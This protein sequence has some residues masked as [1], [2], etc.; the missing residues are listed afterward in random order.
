MA[1]LETSQGILALVDVVNFTSQAD[2]L[3][4]SYTARYTKYFQRKIKTI[5]KKYNF[6]VVKAFGDA[7]LIFGP[8]PEDLLEIMLDLFERVKPKD[9]YGFISRFRMVAHSGYFQ[10]RIKYRRPVDLVSPEGIKVFRMEKH[11]GTWELMVTHTLFQGLNH[12]LNRYRMEAHR[13]VLNEPLKGFDSQEWFP[14]FYRLRIMSESEVVSN[15]LERRLDEL[16]EGV[17]FIPVFGR[18]YDPVRM[19]KNFVN[20]AL[21]W[22]PDRDRD[23]GDSR[24]PVPGDLDFKRKRRGIQEEKDKWL[25]HECDRGAAD[26]VSYID[27]PTLYKNHYRGIIIGLPG[28][29]K[30][31]ILK[32]LAYQEFKGRVAGKEKGKRVILFVPCQGIPLYVDWHNSRFGKDTL[33]PKRDSALEYLTWIFIFGARSHSDVTPEELVEFQGAAKI[34]H[35]A[36]RDNRLT[37]LVDALDEAPDSPSKE[38]IMELFL[39]LA[40]NSLPKT[41]NRFFLTTR[42]S[43]RLHLEQKEIPVFYV[44]SLNLEQVRAVARNLMEEG[45]EI[46][47]KFDQAI[48]QEE[49]VVKMAATPLTALLVTAY[50][51]A[52]EKFHHRFSMYDMLVKF[53]LLRIWESIKAGTFPYKKLDL[54]FQEIKKPGFL[55]KKR[56]IRILYDALASLCFELFY[57]TSD[58][59]IQRDVGEEL[60][61]A[62]FNRFI[63]DHLPYEKEGEPAVQADRW[64]ERFHQDHLLLKAS[65]TRYVFVHSMVMEFLAAYHLVNRIIKNREE[66]VPLVRKCLISKD[67]KELETLPIAAGSELK[68]VYA[69]LSTMRDLDVPYEREI[70]HEVAA[71]CLA[72]LEWQI[73]KTFQAITLERLTKPI[74]D[75]IMQ[76]RGAV[77]WLYK[78]LKKLVLTPDKSCL[79]KSTRKF[80][81]VLKLSQDTFLKEYL[82]YE[83]FDRGDSE[84]VGLRKELLFQLVQK[85]LVEQWLRAHLAAAAENGWQLD[86]P[87]FHFEDKNFRY[88]QAMMGQELQGFLGSPNMRHSGAVRACIFSPDGMTFVS[89]S[90]D[91]TLKLWNAATGKEIRTFIGHA[92][93]V[94]GC[95]FSPDGTLLVSASFD[96]TLKLWEVTNSLEIRTFTGHQGPVLSCSFSPDGSHLASASTDK[97]IKLWKVSGAKAIRTFTGHKDAVYDCTFSPD[98]AYLVSTSLDKTLKLWE[99]ASGKEIR[100]FTGHKAAVSSC[101]FSLDGTNL[102]SASADHTLK[103]WEVKSGKATLTFNEHKGWVYN[104]AFS[105]DGSHLVSASSDRTL[106]LWEVNSGK[107]IRAFTGHTDSVWGCAFSPGGTRLVSASRDNT[108][109]LWEVASGKEIRAFTGHMAPVYSCTFS[110]TG[111]HLVS[112][113]RDKTLKLWEMASGKEIRTFSGH[114]DPVWGCAFSPDGCLLVSASEDK[115]LK[116]WEI[117]S[118]KEIRTFTGH[119]DHIRACAFSPDG[120]LLVSASED[121]TLKLWEMTSGKEIRTFTGH[122]DHIRACAF[123]PDGCLL[124]SASEDETLKLWDTASG[125]I[126][127]FFRRHKDV[128]SSCAFSPDG[129]YLVS[130]SFDKT[131]KLWKLS[132]RRAIRTLK[133]H[134]D[135]VLNCDF[136]QSG[137][138]LVSVSEDKTLKLWEVESGKLLKSMQLPWIPQHV[139]TAKDN[140]VITANENGTLTLFKFEEL[141]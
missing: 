133:G 29:G 35:K 26:E 139:T 55:E 18:I 70:L 127:R 63:Q 78:Y 84:L 85:E 21:Q 105:P 114:I 72:E 45:S 131:L 56:E 73:T 103:L 107:E 3:G 1:D 77:D 4:D 116:L 128:V 10:F 132:N 32:H 136:S 118:G 67:Y 46:Y 42:P 83:D 66:L 113:S 90:D 37:L 117:A 60:L 87:L 109:K 141:E 112:S 43:E 86:S 40:E 64:I 108:L 82:S 38:K 41:G 88:F 123:S 5:V 31:T 23:M 130:A 13:M 9:L 52:Y 47:Q 7:V 14:P 16:E 20:L 58:G 59:K 79:R 8:K 110:P 106:K 126:I 75:L 69:I 120:R 62:Y 111:T 134:T 49:M 138:H 115:T 91:G 96:K 76:N 101:A 81:A 50:F 97:T 24:P 30:T 124:V 57:G 98:G 94:S 119:T 17:Q 68:H 33:V 27:V 140:R 89:A 51:Q 129:T 65:K 11:A 104:C 44:L 135:A 122:T 15:L 80:S 54:F 95:A 53:T 121:K 137:N 19:E 2:K 22:H 61:M 71:K 6:R 93:A 39:L 48:W 102:V 36:Y 12:L 74:L 25:D 92:D 99:L 125:E 28:A 100:T 34:L